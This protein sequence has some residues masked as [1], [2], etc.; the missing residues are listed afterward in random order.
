MM[1]CV[2]K[3]FNDV[4]QVYLDETNVSV[5]YLFHLMDK[6]KSNEEIISMYSNINTESLEV[7]RILF[8]DIKGQF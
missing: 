8:N 1:K 5:F 6:G 7:L 3:V 4:L 2:L